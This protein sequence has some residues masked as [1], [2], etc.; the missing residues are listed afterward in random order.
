MSYTFLKQQ[1]KLSR[2]LGDSNTSTDDA[3]PL[4]DR[5]EELNRG[6]LHFAKDSKAI[7]EYAT[8]TVSGNTITLPADWIETF[9]LV[10]NNKVVTN[11]KEVS[12]SDY[13][14]YYQDTSEFYFYTWEVSG[15]KYI[16]FF[17]SSANG[18][19]YQ[20][21]Y[22]KK[23]TT[24]LS[25]DADE[26]LLPDEYREASAYWAAGELL[27]Q[28]GKTDLATRYKSVYVGYVTQAIE[29]LEKHYIKKEYARPDFGDNTNND[30]VDTQGHGRL[31]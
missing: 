15:I 27:E 8:G 10:V 14:R 6:E 28:I 25:D 22:F 20:L 12:L 31:F 11:D 16:T 24:D 7:R 13:E 23:P 17:N 4:A 5:Q 30:S 18:Q 3:W 21:W 2:L 19:T 1:N 29:D 9:V 26:S